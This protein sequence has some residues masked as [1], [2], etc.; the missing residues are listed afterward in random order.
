[1]RNHTITPLLRLFWLCLIGMTAN[2]LS[3][4]VAFEVEFE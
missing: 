3:P 4:A 2:L 1:M